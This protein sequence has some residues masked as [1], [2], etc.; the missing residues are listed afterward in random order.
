MTAPGWYPDAGSGGQLRWWDGGSWGPM[1]PAVDAYGTS[2][3]PPAG[4][5]QPGT[6]APSNQPYNP[7][8]N[9]S[10][11]YSPYSSQPYSPQGFGQPSTGASSAQTFF[12]R[13]RF[14]LIAVL[15]AGIYIAIAAASHVVLFGILPVL[16]TVRAFR[17]KEKLWPLAAL[18]SGAAIVIAFILL[19]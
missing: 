7:S 9:N 8:G 2:V 1:S 14:S 4:Y 17:A 13:S 3:V 18:A 16:M 5:S 12:Q 11:P 19:R 6:A 10:Q 15:I